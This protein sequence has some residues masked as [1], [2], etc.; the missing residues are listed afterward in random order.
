MEALLKAQLP[1][2]KSVDEVTVDS[3]MKVAWAAE[4][5]L[6][7][8]PAKEWTFN[9]LK[10]NADGRFDDVQLAELIKS[11]IEEPAHAF[12]AHGAPA[13]LKVVELMA[14]LQARNVFKVC[15]LNE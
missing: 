6:L 11:C 5:E 8:T 9:G 7:A 1:S 14:Q 12:G 2:I 10:R 13:S 4:Q 3:F 15:T